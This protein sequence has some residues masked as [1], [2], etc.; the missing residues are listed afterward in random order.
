MCD[1]INPAPPVTRTFCIC[2][3]RDEAPTRAAKRLFL[4]LPICAHYAALCLASDHSAHP[5]ERPRVVHPTER[6]TCSADQNGVP[7]LNG[8]RSR[9]RA[10]EAAISANVLRD[11]ID[12][13]LIAP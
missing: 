6:T 13:A 12:A 7:A 3:S 8:A 10:A 4:A 11:P 2:P 9:W 5:G 1:P